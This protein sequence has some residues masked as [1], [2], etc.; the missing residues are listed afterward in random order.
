MNLNLA[1]E[2]A[3]HATSHS[4]DQ[5]T[6]YSHIKTILGTCYISESPLNDRRG[7]EEVCVCRLENAGL[8]GEVRT[9]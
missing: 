4:G 8:W 9:F 3:L 5:N 7:T 2:Y 1:I 6:C